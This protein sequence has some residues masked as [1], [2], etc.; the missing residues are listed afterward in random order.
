MNGKPI[1]VA[2]RADEWV[3]LMVRIAS[4]GTLERSV[5]VAAFVAAMG[6]DQAVT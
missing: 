4:D 3:E 5:V 1:D 2:E 6:R